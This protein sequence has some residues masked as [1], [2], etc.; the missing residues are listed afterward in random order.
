[1]LSKRD[2]Y[3]LSL[4]RKVATYSKERK[5]HGCVI[6]RS[7]KIVGF[8][9]NKFRNNPDQVSSE[10]IKTGCSYH[11]EVVA[12]RMAGAKAAGATLYVARIN[13]DGLDRN[14]KPCHNCNNAIKV[15]GI[16]RVV[17]TE[18]GEYDVGP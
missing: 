11:A 17:Y 5:R 7:G 4:A 13:I 9:S 16:K 15:A 14:S 8:G 1:M 12:L 10:H 2:E 18:T 6:V 3:W